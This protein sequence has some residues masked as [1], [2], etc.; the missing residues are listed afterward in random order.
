MSSRRRF[1]LVFAP[2][3]KKAR[4]A[5][6][7]EEIAPPLGVLYLAAALRAALPEME[8]H[9]YDGLRYG[10]A[11]TE[12]AIESVKPD[13]LG[14]SYYTTAAEGAYQLAHYAKERFPA[15]RTVLGGP[16]ATA[17]PEEALT[18][19]G[20]D[21]V[22]VG[23]GEETLVVLARLWDQAGAHWEDQIKRI[24]GIA[25]RS[26]GSVVINKPRRYITPLDAIHPP[27]RDMVRL[28]DYRGFYLAK[29]R[30]ETS[31]VMSRGC[32]YSCTFCSNK[33]W[34]VSTPRVRTRSPSSIADEM[35]NL[36][37]EFGIREV[38]D[39]A[40][41]FN[42]NVGVADQICVELIN[43]R[44]GLSWKTQVRATPLPEKL[45]DRM[46]RAGCWYVHLGIES[47]NEETLRG[48]GKS[49]T[50][51]QVKSAC[52][53]LKN[54]GIKVHGLFML[55]NV[56][57]EDGELRYEGV[58]ETARTLAFAESLASEKLLD[59]MGWSVTTPYP[60]SKLYDI[61][62]RHDLIKP[63]LKY[64]WTKWLLDET[65]VMQLPGVSDHDMARAKSRGSVLR[66][67]LMLRSGNVNLSDIGYIAKKGLKLVGNELK[68]MK[69][70]LR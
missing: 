26:N 3:P 58:D 43:R 52:R 44:I 19:P 11:E 5:E 12:A 65:F 8:V 13:Y 37:D 56:W 48:I 62:L 35:E 27:A 66:A 42:A 49:V 63:D 67:K 7:G 68:A 61:A 17:L 60:G 41:E 54:H 57:E 50:L 70:R 21:C 23:E 15:V 22:V 69:G 4:F 53:V 1:L 33:V 59:Y 40:D 20:V 32:P 46:A 34:K 6:L 14:I 39:H 38:F 47:G 51:D 64:S 45:V 36:R 16:H 10:Y 31:M 55:F 28:G 9:V 18:R 30:P 29:A 25:W 2:P 24:D